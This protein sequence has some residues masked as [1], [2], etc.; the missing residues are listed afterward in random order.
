[1]TAS[2]Y[3]AA[4]IAG[5]FGSTHC[6]GMCGGIAGVLGQSISREQHRHYWLIQ[7]AYHIGR[8]G[9][10]CLLGL[11]LGLLVQ[12]TQW[13]VAAVVLAD[14]LR[15]LAALMLIMMGLYLGRWW[16]GLRAMEQWGARLWQ[17]LQRQFLRRGARSQQTLMN[18]VVAGALW[19]L[20]P[21]GLVYSA[22][23]TAALQESTVDRLLFMLMF[24]LGTAPALLATSYIFKR[25]DQNRMMRVR[26][27]GAGVLVILGLFVLYQIAMLYWS[28]GAHSH[29]PI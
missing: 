22:V 18:A 27:W 21:C 6:V 4:L 24:G 8:I 20:L 10:Y 23:A 12:L 17:P 1:M 29:H 5:F 26:Q 7:V 11:V 19:G 16:T 15:A 28:G 3:L 2:F 9:M 25:L 13:Y 14:I